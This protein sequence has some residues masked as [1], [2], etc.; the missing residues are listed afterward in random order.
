MA[1][2][3]VSV[4]IV[5]VVIFATV[6]VSVF[7][8]PVTMSANVANRPSVVDVA[9]TVDEPNKAWLPERLVMTAVFAER[10]VVVALVVV[11]LRPVKFWRVVEP[12]AKKFPVVKF[13]AV[14]FVEY[15]FVVVAFSA[16]IEPAEMPSKEA[17]DPLIVESVID[18]PEILAD[19][20]VTPERRSI[21]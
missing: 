4:D 20:I 21:R 19:A 5:A 8:T 7:T 9:V 10:F 11:E 18:A 2:W 17:E 6:A 15:R 3:P 14:K 12:V 1:L 13:A 16:L